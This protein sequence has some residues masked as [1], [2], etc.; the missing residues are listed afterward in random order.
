MKTKEIGINPESY[1]FRNFPIFGKIHSLI[2]HV[3]MSL[4]KNTV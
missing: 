3:M 2:R 1:A 4:T